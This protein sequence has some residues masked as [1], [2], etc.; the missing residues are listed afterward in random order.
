MVTSQ[1]AAGNCHRRDPERRCEAERRDDN[2]RK[3]QRR[4]AC[5]FRS[6]NAAGAS[7]PLYEKTIERL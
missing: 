4:M 7:H 6:N 3:R 1:R 5:K 2:F